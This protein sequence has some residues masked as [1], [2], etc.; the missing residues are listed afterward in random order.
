MMRT[1][2][3]NGM[4]SLAVKVFRQTRGW[5]NLRNN[6]SVVAIAL[7]IV[8]EPE[9][10]EKTQ[11]VMEIM[12]DTL[13]HEILPTTKMIKMVCQVLFENKALVG[14]HA[15]QVVDWVLNYNI[16]L[17]QK[18]YTQLQQACPQTIGAETNHEIISDA[19]A[20]RQE[21]LLRNAHNYVYSNSDFERIFF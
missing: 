12:Q 14:A 19:D 15:Q 2:K 1:L 7:S 13:Q 18:Q 21:D 6:A 17:L 10:K 16:P 4:P 9:I 8:R 11:M 5:K 3:E 20:K